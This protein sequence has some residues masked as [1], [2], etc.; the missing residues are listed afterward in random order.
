MKSVC[1]MKWSR[2][3][4]VTHGQWFQDNMSCRGLWKV[5]SRRRKSQDDNVSGIKYVLKWKVSRSVKDR[6]IRH[7]Y[8]A[9]PGQDGYQYNF[10][11]SPQPKVLRLIWPQKWW[12]CHEKINQYAGH[13]IHINELQSIS[14]Y[15][16]FLRSLSCSPLPLSI[17][18]LNETRVQSFIAYV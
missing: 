16:L 9:R 10:L 6:R 5:V 17:W 7:C 12:K 3:T 13:W 14:N 15:S 18:K 4:R 2:F 8:Q 11:L 1:D